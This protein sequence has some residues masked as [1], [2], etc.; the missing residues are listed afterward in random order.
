MQPSAEIYYDAASAQSQGRREQQEDAVVADFPAGAGMGFAVLSDGMGGHAAGDVAS[1]IVVTEIFS[2]LKMQSGNPKGLEEDIS[3]ILQ[4]AVQSAND[5]VR[6]HAETNPETMGMGA[7]LIAPVLLGD[8]LYWISVGDSPLYLYRDGRLARLN[9]DHS[10]LAQINYLVSHGMMERETAAN[11]PD[12]HALTSVLIGGEIAKIDCPARPVR[13]QPNDVILVA[14]DGLQ[15][16]SETR[17]AELIGQGA[18]QSSAEIGAELLRALEDLDDPD[19]DNISLCVIRVS[20]DPAFGLE[21]VPPAAMAAEPAAAAANVARSQ[22]TIV[23]AAS[24]KRKVVT[25]RVSMER[26]A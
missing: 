6:Y 15:Y 20:D 11:H 9:E 23:A 7:T 5:C 26:S 16:L 17:I 22:M 14:S 12:R 13:V 10:M 3:G 2:E 18:S 21:A 19:Q 1:K 8:R 24:R 4:A 25:Y